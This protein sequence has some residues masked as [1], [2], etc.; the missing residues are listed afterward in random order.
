[1]LHF[2]LE[3]FRSDGLYEDFKDIL[4][5]VSIGAILSVM[6]II[7][8]KEP[9][10]PLQIPMVNYIVENFPDYGS[11]PYVTQQTKDGL[12]C[13]RAHRFRWYHY[14]YVTVA[15]VKAYLI[16]FPFLAKLNAFRKKI[17]NR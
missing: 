4:E 5:E 12:A 6:E 9:E 15:K 17:M 2:I 13:L 14:R 3:N 8:R 16:R 11:N 7:N 10:H 1:M